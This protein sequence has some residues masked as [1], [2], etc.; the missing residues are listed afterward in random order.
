MILFI[1]HKIYNFIH[2]KSLNIG[3]VKNKGFESKDGVFREGVLKKMN[4][5]KK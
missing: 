2:V 3:F 1:L 4:I 5:V